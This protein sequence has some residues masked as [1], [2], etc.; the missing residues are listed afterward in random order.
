MSVVIS[1]NFA[2][3]PNTEGINA[4][5]PIFGYDNLATIS[6]L[7]ASSQDTDHPLINITNP[8][9]YLTW[10]ATGVG[11]QII[12]FSSGEE[13]PAEIDYVGIAEHNC[14]STGKTI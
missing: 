6:T 14:G 1:S 12:T 10:K 9:T 11:E 2:I 3:A 13:E 5:N 4:N 8:A 7:S